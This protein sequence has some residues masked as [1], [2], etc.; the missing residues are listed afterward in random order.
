MPFNLLK[1]LDADDIFI[2]Y[3][4]DGE[5]NLDGLSDELTKPGFACFDD[6]QGTDAGPL[7]PETLF[8][9]IRSCRT[10]A[11]LETPG[12]I[13]KSKYLAEE[14]RH[15]AETNGT[16]RIIAVRHARIK[17]SYLRL[18]SEAAAGGDHDAQF[19]LRNWQRSR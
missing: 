5:T 14:V 7:P 15:F 10:L 6:R 11:L 16:T 13:R 9:K 17:R 18:L 4:R 1:N 12:A 19:V 8:R 2:S 3:S